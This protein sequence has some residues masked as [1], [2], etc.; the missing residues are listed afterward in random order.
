[1]GSCKNKSHASSA[2]A[3]AMAMP[4]AAAWVGYQ[5][6]SD[7]KDSAWRFCGFMQKPIACKLGSSQRDDRA[8]GCGMGW[9]SKTFGSKNF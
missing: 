7:P 4:W 5:K 6:L 3:N 2:Q 8:F 9:L 1:M